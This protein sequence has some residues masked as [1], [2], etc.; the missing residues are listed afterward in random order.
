[1]KVLYIGHYKEF[2][3]WGRAAT[4]QIL[5]LDKAGVDVVCRNIT[6]TRDRQNLDPKLLELESKSFTPQLAQ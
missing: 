5:A 1:M 3:G 6:L 4:D 2:G